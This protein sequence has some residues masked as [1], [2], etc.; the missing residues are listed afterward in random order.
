MSDKRKDG[1]IM[2]PLKRSWPIYKN[3]FKV[4]P[5]IVYRFIKEKLSK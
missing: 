2:G 3:L 1:E 4:L 5:I